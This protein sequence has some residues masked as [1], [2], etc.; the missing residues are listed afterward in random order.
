MEKEKT[1]N[2]IQSADIPLRDKALLYVIVL[3]GPKVREIKE[4]RASNITVDKNNM[5]LEFGKRTVSIED[6]KARFT[7]SNWASQANQNKFNTPLFSSIR[8]NGELTGKP[9]S[10][11]SINKILQR[12]FPGTNVREFRRRFISDVMEQDI[13]KKDMKKQIGVSSYTAL[14]HY[15]NQTENSD[16]PE[17]T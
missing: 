14:L 5:I 16:K 17:V 6:K 2:I 8:K 13:L 4:L 11:V 15:S 9:M 12:T 1:L 7:I 10:D 3:C